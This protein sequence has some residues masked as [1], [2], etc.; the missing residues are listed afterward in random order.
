MLWEKT[1]K[2]NTQEVPPKKSFFASL[3]SPFRASAPK[4][5]KQSE[6][7]IIP[8]IEEKL[9]NSPKKTTLDQESETGEQSGI[10]DSLWRSINPF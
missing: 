8:E 5:E 10:L 3:L 9:K 2:E 4:T 7:T 1:V 6:G